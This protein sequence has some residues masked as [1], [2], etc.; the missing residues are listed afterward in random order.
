VSDIAVSP[1]DDLAVVGQGCLYVHKADGRKLRFKVPPHTPVSKVAWYGRNTLLVGD[2]VN[3][4][5]LV[6]EVQLTYGPRDTIKL[7]HPLAD[8]AVSSN[9]LYYLTEK[10][11]QK[12]FYSRL[13]SE[14]GTVSETL[15][16]VELSMQQPLHGFLSIAATEDLLVGV[17]ADGIKIFGNDGSERATVNCEKNAMTPAV[18]LDHEHIYI[19]RK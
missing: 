14:D 9:I 17:R 10:D 15:H 8:M 1:D 16:F 12:I 11:A 6:Y 3:G 5:I 4:Q 7:D 2:T 13:G 18:D 19:T